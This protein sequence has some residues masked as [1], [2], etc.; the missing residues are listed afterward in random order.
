VR[1]ALDRFRRRL[2][3]RGTALLA[4]GIPWIVYGLGLMVAPR[5]GLLRAAS[6]LTAQLGLH[7]WG[8]IWMTCG[9]LSCVAALL[10][11]GQDQWGFAFA[12]APP[13]V[14]GLAYLV[15]AIRGDYREAWASMPLLVAPVLLLLVVAAMTGRRCRGSG[16]RRGQPDGQ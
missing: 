10:R 15:A 11:R 3:W 14:W 12:A 7:C 6:V 13:L 2:G 5:P 4:C 16:V 9:L 1:A 8:V